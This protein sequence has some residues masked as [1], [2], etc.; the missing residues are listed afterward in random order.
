MR[1]LRTWLLIAGL[2]AGSPLP[3]TA[4][5]EHGKV[6]W[7][8]WSED[9]FQRAAAEHKFVLLHLAAGW[10]HWRHICSLPAFDGATLAAALDR[11]RRPP[12]TGG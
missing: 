1:G 7:Q 9:L 5:P 4:A 8:G 11:L 2:L 10:C 12:P 6:P 3:A